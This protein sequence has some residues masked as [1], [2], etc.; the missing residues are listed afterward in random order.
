MIKKTGLILFV[1]F[2][3]FLFSKISAGYDDGESVYNYQGIPG[4]GC[5]Y[6]CNCF[7]YDL[8]DF[9][10]LNQSWHTDGDVA[11]K[12]WHRFMEKCLFSLD[13]GIYINKDL[14]REN[15]RGGHDYYIC[16]LSEYLNA[17]EWLKK[18]QEKY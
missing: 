14:F 10:K 9:L 4:C 5:F 16:L 17:I 18:T 6:H 11:N 1:L 12:I 2:N 15:L 7:E 8:D 13:K 3:L